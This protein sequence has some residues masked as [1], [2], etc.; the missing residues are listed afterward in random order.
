MQ[1]QAEIHTEPSAETAQTRHPS[2]SGHHPPAG[3]RAGHGG[4]AGGY[5]RFFAMVAVA[6]GIMFVMMYLNSARILEHAWFSETRFYMGLLMGAVMVAVMLAFMSGMYRNRKTNAGIFAGAAV[7]AVLS[8]W[9]VRSQVTVDDVDYMEGMI[10]HHSIAILTSAR[11]DIR[12][13]RVRDLADGILAAQRKEIKEMEWLIKDIRA[14]GPA[15]NR[16][17]AA[18]RSVPYF[19]APARP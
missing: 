1:A 7:F 16:E 15:L 8:L 19:S 3:H 12:D 10:P 2:H 14:Y 6:T 4:H 18:L 9:L 13:P 5:A 17:Q 11:A